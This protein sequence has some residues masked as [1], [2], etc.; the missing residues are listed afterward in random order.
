MTGTEIRVQGSDEADVFFPL[1]LLPAGIS[2][3]SVMPGPGRLPLIYHW[4][5]ISF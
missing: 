3:R 2:R 5:A 1:G 4:R